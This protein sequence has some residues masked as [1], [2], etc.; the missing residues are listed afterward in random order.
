MIAQNKYYNTYNPTKHSNKLIVVIG[1][2]KQY[3]KNRINK[4]PPYGFALRESGFSKLIFIESEC[5]KLGRHVD[6]MNGVYSL[7]VSPIEAPISR[8][9]QVSQTL[10]TKK[11]LILYINLDE[12]FVKCVIAFFCIYSVKSHKWNEDYECGA[13]STVFFFL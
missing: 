7:V 4:K 1:V 5:M 6:I 2:L 9:T 8:M 12:H 13:I 10:E 11:K 3:A